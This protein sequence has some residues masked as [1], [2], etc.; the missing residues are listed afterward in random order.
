MPRNSAPDP[1][2][3]PSSSPHPSDLPPGTP[4]P[5]GD[6]GHSET[7]WDFTDIDPLSELQL[8]AIELTMQGHTDVAIA[9]MLG[10]NR[11]TLWRW[12]NLDDDYRRVLNNARIQLY[13]T[14]ADR[15]QMLL[16][17]ATGVMSQN[18]QDSAEENRFRAAIAILNMAGSFRPL[19]PKYFLTNDTLPARREEHSLMPMP[20]LP[21]KMG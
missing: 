20:D 8:Q 14:A 18:L 7:R 19:P 13:A 17:R 2:P 9:E 5:G 11:R 3:I 10:I 16:T 6:L 4:P 15:Y 12:K 1:N 21:E